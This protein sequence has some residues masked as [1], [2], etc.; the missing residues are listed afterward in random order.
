MFCNPQ[1]GQNSRP[2]SSIHD[3]HV[4]ALSMFLA[5]SDGRVSGKK[6]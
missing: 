1:N 6:C 4:Q 5:I 2:K 3:P